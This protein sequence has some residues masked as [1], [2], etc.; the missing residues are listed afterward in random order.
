MKDGA[1]IPPPLESFY[2]RQTNAPPLADAFPGKRA[3]HPFVGMA[4]VPEEDVPGHWSRIHAAQ[5]S[6][7]AV[8]YV[9]VPF[10]RIIACSAASI[11][12]PGGRTRA[13]L[14]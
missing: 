2:A 9:H 5:R 7:R 13:R 4:A 14:T 12:T 6:N 11:R 8:A 1:A 3:V 10:A